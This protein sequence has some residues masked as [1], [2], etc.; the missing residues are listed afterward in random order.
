MAS[1]VR[2]FL[3]ARLA[4]FDGSSASEQQPPSD[5]LSLTKSCPP[6]WFSPR[7]DGDGHSVWLQTGLCPRLGRTTTPPQTLGAA[8]ASPRAPRALPA[9]GHCWHLLMPQHSL[10]RGTRTLLLSQLPA[11]LLIA[12]LFQILPLSSAVHGLG[13]ASA[14]RSWLNKP[15]GGSLLPLIFSHVAVLCRQQLYPIFFLEERQ[16]YCA[17]AL[18]GLGHGGLTLALG[19]C[20][21]DTRGEGGQGSVSQPFPDQASPQCRS[22]QAVPSCQWPGWPVRGR[23]DMVPA[24]GGQTVSHLAQSVSMDVACQKSEPMG[25]GLDQYSAAFGCGASVPLLLCE[26]GGAWIK[27]PQPGALPGG[28]ASPLC[29]APGESSRRHRVPGR[30]SRGAAP[31]AAACAPSGSFSS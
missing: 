11:A 1:T 6:G 16:L 2:L 12:V 21:R 15:S 25:A 8:L 4:S 7:A 13:L 19:P 20:G 3:D 26:A 30:G 31:P 18:L 23:A 10:Q 14:P 27:P 9:V 22:G 28:S 5:G 17:C 29:P 24:A